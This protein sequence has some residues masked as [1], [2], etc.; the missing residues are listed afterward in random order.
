MMLCRETLQPRK[1]DH[2]II[3]KKISLYKKFGTPISERQLQTTDDTKS[4]DGRKRIS[5]DSDIT[6]STV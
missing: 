1:P 3:N 5:S 6:L 4:S 2:P